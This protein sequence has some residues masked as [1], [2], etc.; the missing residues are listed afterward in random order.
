MCGKGCGAVQSE[1]FCPL[2]DTLALTA[3]SSVVV[4]LSDFL[5]PLYP[6]VGPICLEESGGSGSGE[7]AHSTDGPVES[8]LGACT[9]LG[10]Q[11]PRH[12]QL[13]ILASQSLG[14]Q[15]VGDMK[16]KLALEKMGDRRCSGILVLRARGC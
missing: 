12:G 11:K 13:C 6:V 14:D 9:E 10:F 1:S 15:F 7:R 5:T 4:S 3:C 16:V 2:G 8:C